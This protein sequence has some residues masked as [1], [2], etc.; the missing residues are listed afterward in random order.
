MIE[1][2]G[3][4]YKLCLFDTNVLSDFLI[5]PKDWI[6]YLGRKFD[7]SQTVICYSVFTLSELYR[8]QELFEKYIDFFAT[9]PSTLLDGHESIFQ[10]EIEK[11]K[12]RERPNPI[13]LAPFAIKESRLTAKQRLRHIIEKS[14]FIARTDYWIKGQQQI[15][16]GIVE[17]KKNYLSKNDKYSKKEVEEFCFIASIDQIILRDSNFAK[18]VIDK[19]EN[20]NLEFFPSVKSTSYVVFYK[21]YPDNRQ[22]LLSDV[23]DILISSLLPYVDYFLTESNLSNIIK[24][25][26]KRHKALSGL[27]TYSLKQIRKEMNV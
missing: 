13:V 8:R 18:S 14:D 21:F 7:I 1:L 17:L 11:Y 20:I 22:P 2:N 15:L 10:K 24:I 6:G 19:G 25:I 23:F 5:N 4:K 16:D 3:N 12:S 27:K 9:F 26:Q